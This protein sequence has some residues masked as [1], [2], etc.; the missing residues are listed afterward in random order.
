[1]ANGV[2]QMSHSFGKQLTGLAT[3]ATNFSSQIKHDDVANV[4]KVVGEIERQISRRK[5]CAGDFF[6]WQTKFGEIDHLSV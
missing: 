5:L 6:A 2:W 4:I 3:S 1:M